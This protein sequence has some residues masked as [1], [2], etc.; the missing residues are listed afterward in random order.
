M[1]Q[2]LATAALLAA[3]ALPALAS[4]IG[5][6]S[7]TNN[8]G[9]ANQGT[10][11]NSTL[12][13]GSVGSGAFSPSASASSTNVNTAFG[14][15]AKSSS[16]SSSYSSAKQEQ[17]QFQA[18]SQSAKS[19]VKDSGNS[20]ASVSVAAQKRNPVATAYAAPLVAA[21]DTCMGSTSAG[22]Q[23][24][25]FGLS[26]GSTWSDAD[27]VRRKDARELHNM[28]YRPAAIALLCQ[29]ANV[30]KAMKDAGTPC[31]GSEDDYVPSAGHS[32]SFESEYPTVSG[33][34]AKH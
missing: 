24:V 30:R 34:P 1:R 31:V 12:N 15:S 8:D 22:G 2:L 9:I 7:I 29:S 10:I 16:D 26:I 11:Q 23:G 18:Q 13:N 4:G 32:A 21:D 17:G 33:S 3:F 28:G 5:G 25:G 27:C 14:G 20:K 19:S 6:D